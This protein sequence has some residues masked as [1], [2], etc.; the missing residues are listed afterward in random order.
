MQIPRVCQ[1]DA[2]DFQLGALADRFV[3]GLPGCAI[4]KQ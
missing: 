1:N 4:Q 3:T 2:S